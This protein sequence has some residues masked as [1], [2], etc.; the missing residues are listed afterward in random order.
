MK[1]R[2]TKCGKLLG[3][4]DGTA[5]AEIK[6]P[7]CDTMNKYSIKPTDI[8]KEDVEELMKPRSYKRVNGAL[9]ETR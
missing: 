6:C 1:L 7:R 4:I 8:N 2:C 9:R 5:D 3:K